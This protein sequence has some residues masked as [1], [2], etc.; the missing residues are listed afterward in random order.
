MLLN[1]LFKRPVKLHISTETEDVFITEAE[2]NGRTIKVHAHQPAP[3][4]S[5]VFWFEE[6]GEDEHGMPTRTLN[7]TGSGGEL[8]VFALVKQ[9]MEMFVKK[10]DPKAVIFEATKQGGDDRSNLY[11]KFLAKYAKNYDVHETKRDGNTV[12]KLE[13]K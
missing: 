10:Y 11:R 7:Q 8:D 1:E 2:I 12:F 3:S 4:A 13:K 5:W 6:E 9:T